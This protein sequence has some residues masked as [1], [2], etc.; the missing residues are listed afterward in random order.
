MRSAL[1][2]TFIA[3]LL[4][5]MSN[6]R[7][8]DPVPTAEERKA[9]EAIQK[10][11]GTGTI[12]AELPTEARVAAKFPAMTDLQLANV[13]GVPHLGALTTG[14]CRRATDRGIANLAGVPQ[15]RKLTLSQGVVTD[16][17]AAAVAECKELRMLYL[18]GG[19]ITDA[20]V[21]A[22]KKLSRLEILDLSNNPAIS[23]RGMVHLAE[24]G[25]LG[26]LYLGSTAITDHGLEQLRTLEGLTR[27][28]VV[29]TKISTAAAEKF[30]RE[31]PNLRQV[32]R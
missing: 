24:M 2:L 14:D 8:E 3:I 27:L 17:T 26:E 4:S 10:M 16:R 28:N 29:N 25:R 19:K 32:R 22:L 7:G 12:D 13:K 21:A 5:G 11:G 18:G 15:L 9:I 1:L 31:M 20:G 23:D 30:E 6:A